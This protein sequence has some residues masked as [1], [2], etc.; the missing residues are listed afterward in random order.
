M[1]DHLSW[2]QRGS[3]LDWI[4]L[5]RT[6]ERRSWQ[7]GSGCEGLAAVKLHW[8]RNY[9]NRYGVDE[10]SD[11]K[12]SLLDPCPDSK[13]VG[14]WTPSFR[15]LTSSFSSD[16]ASL[17]QSKYKLTHLNTKTR[18]FKCRPYLIDVSLNV[19][20]LRNG[21]HQISATSSVRVCQL[22]QQLLKAKTERVKINDRNS[23]KRKLKVNG[24]TFMYLAAAVILPPGLPGFWFLQERAVLLPPFQE[25]KTDESC[26]APT[27]PV[28]PSQWTGWEFL[29][30]T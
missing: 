20:I 26:G 10:E 23:L 11:E 27:C 29:W 5:S 18:I 2:S 24:A 15:V 6:P 12:K 1:I 21:P 13:G 30:L 4:L 8:S 16:T 17:F 9:G 25:E 22:L 14:L 7:L 3:V 28:S 19:R